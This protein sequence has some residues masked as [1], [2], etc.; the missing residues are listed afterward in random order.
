VLVSVVL[1][2]LG[3][4][5]AA[6]GTALRAWLEEPRRRREVW[7]AGVDRVPLQSREETA[8]GVAGW[9]G[10]LRVK[11]EPYRRSNDEEG[12]RLVV[13]GPGLAASRFSIRAE[14][15]DTSILHRTG[16][17]DVGS[18]DERFDRAVWIEGAEALVLAVLDAPTRAAL[19]SLVHGQL[20]RPGRSSFWVSARFERGALNVE[21][22]ERLPPDERAPLGA[23]QEAVSRDP[24]YCGG[25]PEHL[26]DAVA[27]ALALARRLIVPHDVP[28]RLLDNLKSE[29]EAAVRQRL[30]DVL[31][32]R[33]PLHRQT[34]DAMRSALEDPDAD[35]RLRAAAA[36]GAGAR[37]V[38]LAVAHGE[39]AADETSVRAVNAL[40]GSLTVEEASAVL[41]NALRLRKLET[42][43]AG[44]RVLGA[45]GGA[46]ALAMLTRVLAVERGE[47]G[48]WAAEALGATGDP[49]AEPA[50][51]RELSA[52]EPHRRVAV[53]RALGHA[54][55]VAA[56]PA[57]RALEDQDPRLKRAAREA[58]ALIQGRRAGAEPG[59]LSLAEAVTGRLS[60]ADV[61]AGRLSFPSNR[62]AGR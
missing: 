61:E 58:I 22:P 57:L 30:L 3:L 12:T 52:R 53:A 38:V 5:L 42:A 45:R 14:S 62:E 26:P 8:G 37:P 1:A 28:Q 36:I 31:E 9:S 23:Q 35:V 50:L 10:N 56:V 44:L 39:G 17:H 46:E 16:R 19:R 47:A 29:P 41:R 60:I 21:L 25:L 27:A 4:G 6:A 51:V 20:V 18:G 54:G 13:T 43:R 33:F 15:L 59:Q 34:T 24:L 2:G 32:S 11:L 7:R 40:S 55:T 49:A 48:D